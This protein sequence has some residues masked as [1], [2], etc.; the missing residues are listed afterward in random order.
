MS[1]SLESFSYA[2]LTLGTYLPHRH[3]SGIDLI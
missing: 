1:A 2:E 3:E